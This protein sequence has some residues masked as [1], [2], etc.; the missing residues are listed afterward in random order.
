MH[1]NIK[2]RGA[3]LAIG[4]AALFL[5][6]PI[7]AFV[8]V[9]PNCVGYLLLC[10]GLNRLAD[11]SGR[12]SEAARRFRIL[13]LLGFVS[14][15]AVYLIYGVMGRQTAQMNRYEQPVYILLAS[16]VA[17]LVQWYFLIPAFRDLFDGIGMLA[18]R[19][20]S[21]RLTRQRRGKTLT[22][23]MRSA[24]TRTL[25]L[26]SSLSLLPELT[27]LTWF[28]YHEENPFFPF[29]WY[30]YV[31]LF[32]FACGAIA[33]VIGLIWLVRMIRFCTVTLRDR[34][35]IKQLRSQYCANVL[36]KTGMLTVRRFSTSF[37]LLQIALIF[38]LNLRMNQRAVLP[39]LIFAVLTVLAIFNLGQ[40]FPREWRAPCNAACVLLTLG[41]L[42]HLWVS[43]TYFKRYLPEAS[44]YD[45][46]AYREFLLVRVADTV[47]ILLTFLLIV[48]LF[49]CLTR[50]AQEQTGVDY[51]GER[52]R[53]LSADATERLHR[54][55]LVRAN[56][57]VAIFFVA[58]L[59]SVLEA[60]L[61][62]EHPW[63]WLPSFLC[64]LAGIWSAWSFLFEL[65]TQVQ[66]RYHSDG[67]NKDL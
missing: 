48:L 54:D 20:G 41:S 67:V 44:L 62:L 58:A 59:I 11:L 27:V 42:L 5:C 12:L 40:F 25:V 32:R 55:F 38:A 36:P 34:A 33:F 31:G 7:V 6:N 43:G 28:E 1:S 16:F 23:R 50:I 52:A 19:H 29:D 35:W 9:L 2:M 21:D 26:L 47:E 8:D 57:T 24:T 64:S 17:M 56:V 46:E 51:G 39:S 53:Y 63:L 66:Y 37:L 49:R 22:E 15:L 14:L 18:E 3:F 61:R 60:W 10:I 13:L 4:A 65:K 30:Q 45:P